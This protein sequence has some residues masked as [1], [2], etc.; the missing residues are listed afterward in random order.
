[1]LRRRQRRHAP[2]RTAAAP[3]SPLSIAATA[4]AAAAGG[5][6]GGGTLRLV[7]S[8]THEGEL[9]LGAER[10]GPRVR[11]VGRALLRHRTD[12]R[13]A[14]PRR[15]GVRVDDAAGLEGAPGSR[16]GATAVMPSAP[17]R[18][19]A[20]ARG[21]FHLPVARAV[22]HLA[23]AARVSSGWQRQLQP[24]FPAAAARARATTWRLMRRIDLGCRVPRGAAADQRAH[25]LRA[26]R[27]AAGARTRRATSPPPPPSRTLAAPRL[28][29]R[30]PSSS[31]SLS[32]SAA[33]ARGQRVAVPLGRHA[34]ALLVTAPLRRSSSGTTSTVERRSS[35]HGTSNTERRTRSR[36]VRSSRAIDE[37]GEP[38]PA[39]VVAPRSWSRA[40]RRRAS[41]ARA[42]PPCTG[43]APSVRGAS[44][45]GA[46]RGGGGGRAHAA[47]R[48]RG[49][50]P[51]AAAEVD[52]SPRARAVSAPQPPAA[53]ARWAAGGDQKQIAGRA[54]ARWRWAPAAARRA[55]RRPRANRAAARPPAP[56]G[57]R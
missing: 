44:R 11:R 41:I 57:R 48:V 56:R 51:V 38:P 50:P 46:A 18:A 21:R 1:M 15:G 12:G 52:R 43:G 27:R 8:V 3:P 24:C 13:H 28:R 6:G 53:A 23:A 2:P 14:T 4:A 42:A 22:A 45:H 40:R 16:A 29:R 26:L 49:A 54:R 30:Q 10:S 37:T 9:D 39:R 32:P 25:L 33:A 7:L 17:H 35:R 19:V 31:L 5:L 20:R 55:A 36:R 34:L 47:R